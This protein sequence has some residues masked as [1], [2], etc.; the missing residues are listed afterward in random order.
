MKLKNYIKYIQ[1]KTTGQYPR[2]LM[3]GW[4]YEKKSSERGT[5]NMNIGMKI[6]TKRWVLLLGVNE[7]DAPK[8]LKMLEKDGNFREFCGA[9]L[10][11]K[12]EKV[13]CLF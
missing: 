12:S 7:R 6:E 11:E 2:G 10:S 3:L 4:Q 1:H 13:C 5:F 8:F 9:D